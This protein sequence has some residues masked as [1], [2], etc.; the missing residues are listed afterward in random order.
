MNWNDVPDGLKQ[1]CKKW[2]LLRGNFF[3]VEDRSF[4]YDDY[5]RSEFYKSIICLVE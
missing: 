2:Y 1:L 3:L 5:Y 4:I